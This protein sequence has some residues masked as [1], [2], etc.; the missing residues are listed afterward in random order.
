MAFKGDI[1]K[2]NKKTPLVIIIQNIDFKT[3]RITRDEKVCNKKSFNTLWRNTQMLIIVIKTARLEMCQ[4]F[5][6]IIK[7]YNYI[8]ILQFG[9]Y[10]WNGN[11]PRKIQIIQNWLK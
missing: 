9:K 10:K 8:F 7:G 5:K 2:N 11:I 4:R 3:K 6:L 1:E